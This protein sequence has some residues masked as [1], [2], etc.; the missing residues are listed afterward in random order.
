M[1]NLLL[2]ALGL[3]SALTLNGQQSGL[4]PDQKKR[5]AIE[6]HKSLMEKTA[7]TDSLLVAL[8]ANGEKI[9]E[10]KSGSLMKQK[11]DSSEWTK[12]DE[13]ISKISFVWDAKGRSILKTL[14]TKDTWDGEY[15]WYK[16]TV[17]FNAAGKPTLEATFTRIL[18]TEPWVIESQTI[19]FYDERGN[20]LVNIF[21]WVNEMGGALEQVKEEN[22]YDSQNQLTVT[23]LYEWDSTVHDWQFIRKA[24][25]SY[26]SDG[27]VSSRAT[28]EWPV[29][30]GEWVQTEQSEFTYDAGGRETSAVS[31]LFN[32]ATGSWDGS[33]RYE[34]A[35][36]S[37]GNKIEMK[38]FRWD[39][40]VR[41]WN[42]DSQTVSTYNSRDQKT[43]WISYGRNDPAGPLVPI[44]RES[45]TY[46]ERGNQTSYVMY[47]EFDV[48]T[49]LWIPLYKETSAYDAGNR[50]VLRT[51]SYYSG[52]WSDS[53][54]V[55]STYDSYGNLI[56]GIQFSQKD[57]NGNWTD[58]LELDYF[59]NQAYYQSEVLTDFDRF[60]WTP[61]HEFL[62]YKATRLNQETGERK[63]VNSVNYHYSD[64]NS[65]SGVPVNP[66]GSVSVFPNPVADNLL[67][68][69]DQSGEPFS[70][71]MTDLTGKQVIFRTLE[72]ITNRV[73]VIDLPAGLYLY[74]IVMNGK[75]MQ[76]KIIKR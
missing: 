20:I 1:R 23:A 45:Y 48:V 36:D 42:I 61:V 11:M 63:T 32:Q 18:E 37:H 56:H 44:I 46:D 52:T 2:L 66:T 59:Y 62:G 30:K 15:H 70:F 19:T 41:T 55:E 22:T 12:R 54:S 7:P 6:F 3:F 71:E 72:G 65:G 53:Y 28:Y 51:L 17:A 38:S 64:F 74:R 50:I 14:Y 73:S 29:E 24:E 33:W 8:Q 9:R 57:D 67:V 4:R 76:G 49:G 60:L 13:L 47:I 68:V 5:L 35:Y 10:M 27:N 58:R 69:T 26:D 43:E 34:T 31:Y 25:I 40:D 16:D 21:A 75:S 39:F